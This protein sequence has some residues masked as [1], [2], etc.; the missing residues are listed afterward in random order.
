MTWTGSR[1][2]VAWVL[3]GDALLSGLPSCEWD[4]PLLKA[5]F[6]DAPAFR[7]PFL[8]IA[9]AVLKGSNPSSSPREST[10]AGVTEKSN[11]KNKAAFVAHGRRLHLEG[12]LHEAAAVLEDVLASDENEPTALLHLAGVYQE[13]G[14]PRRATVAVD[15]LLDVGQLTVEARSFV[16]NLRGI[17]LTSAGDLDGARESYELALLSQDGQ[18]NRH[19]LYNL[20]LL[21]HYSMVPESQPDTSVL[22]IEQAI[23]LYRAAL[24]RGNASPALV[25]KEDRQG[26]RAWHCSYRS[27][28]TT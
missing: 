25:V 6:C 23:G 3:A 22:L 10:T 8:A 14:D 19:A 13:L 21:L 27:Q 24:G 7:T 2:L 9:A 12:S 28:K 17:Y 15:R 18:D 26:F 20:A 1:C 11:G 16:L 5:S 4:S